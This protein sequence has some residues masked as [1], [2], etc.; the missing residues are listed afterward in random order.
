METAEEEKELLEREYLELEEENCAKVEVES[1]ISSFEELETQGQD[2]TQYREHK[3]EV[4][5]LDSTVA[6]TTT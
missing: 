4:F 6:R 1:L 3:R 2:T 5:T